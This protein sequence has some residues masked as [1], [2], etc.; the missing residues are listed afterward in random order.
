MKDSGKI[1]TCKDLDFTIGQMDGSIQVSSKTTKSM[2]TDFTLG[3]TTEGTKATGIGIS[4]M[5]LVLI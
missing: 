3:K 5:D 4:S 2:A 1:I